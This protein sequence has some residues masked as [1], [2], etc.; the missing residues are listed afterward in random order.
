MADELENPATQAAPAE[1]ALEV[2]AGKFKTRLRKFRTDTKTSVQRAWGVLGDFFQE[3]FAEGRNW[4][5]RV[6]LIWRLFWKRGVGLLPRVVL[7]AAVAYVISPLDFIPVILVDDL[8]VIL[9]GAKFFLSLTPD[10]LLAEEQK[11]LGLLEDA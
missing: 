1:Q 8:G 6:R 10:E 7:I 4:L 5:K 2:P 11:K 3:Q 9:L